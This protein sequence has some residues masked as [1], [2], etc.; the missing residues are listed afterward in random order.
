MSAAARDQPIVARQN[1]GRKFREEQVEYSNTL[2]WE[3]RVF[4]DGN[5]SEP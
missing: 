3:L 1:Q 5:D 2:N 4:E